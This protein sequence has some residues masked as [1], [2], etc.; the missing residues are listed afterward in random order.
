MSQKKLLQFNPSDVLRSG[1]DGVLYLGGIK[2]SE[3]E[4]KN[5][6]AEVQ[7]FK[8]LRL[9]KIFTETVR[10]Q[11][12]LTMFENAKTFD[13]MKSGKAMLHAIGVLESILNAVEKAFALKTKVVKS[14]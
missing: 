11:A 4:V 12:R 13:D 3:Q 9:Y 6:D 5:L 1:K 8:S 14:K 10:E 2:L 7:Y